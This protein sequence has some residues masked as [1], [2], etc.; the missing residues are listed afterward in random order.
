MNFKLSKLALPYM[1][2]GSLIGGHISH[3][4]SNDSTLNVYNS[5]EKDDNTFGKSLVLFNHFIG[6]FSGCIIGSAIGVPIGI[7]YVYF[8]Y[9]HNYDILKDR[10]L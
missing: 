6:V 1:V 8:K 10:K 2:S 9:K 5:C 7:S 3:H 4:I